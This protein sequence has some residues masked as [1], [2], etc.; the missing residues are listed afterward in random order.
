[1]KYLKVSN[2]KLNIDSTNDD[3]I[4]EAIKITGINEHQISGANILV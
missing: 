4:K 2:I 3:A 1:M